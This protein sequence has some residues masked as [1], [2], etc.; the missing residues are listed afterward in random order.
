VHVSPL[1]RRPQNYLAVGGLFLC[2][3]LLFWLGTHHSAVPGWTPIQWRSH[4]RPYDATQALLAENERL[5]KAFNDTRA[6][7]EQA[8]SI[9]TELADE[10]NDTAA[11]THDPQDS[12]TTDPPSPAEPPSG[13]AYVFYAT[14]DPY[15]CSALVNIH[16]LRHL[17]HARHPI[18]VLA[19]PTVSFP[20]IA[21]FRNAGAVVHIQTPPPLKDSG[22]GIGG[23]LGGG[24]YYQDCLLKLLAFKLHRLD[25]TLTR[26]L[27][28]D[29]DQLI[30]R[31]L[32]AL[33]AGLPPVD[34]AAPRAYW[35]AK[36][37]LASTFLLINLSDRLWATVEAAM[38]SGGQGKG[39]FDM[40]LLNEVLGD[41]VMM[42]SGEFVTLNSHWED[43]NL[44]GWYHAR[45][46]FNMTAVEM[47]DEMA[48]S[49]SGLAAPGADGGTVSPVME[50]GTAAARYEAGNRRRANG[51]F[52]L[53]DPAPE[54][55]T[56]QP[57]APLSALPTSS[58]PQSASPDTPAPQRDPSPQETPQQ[59][60]PPPPPS[61]PL[62][63][64]AQPRFPAT[65]PLSI[66]LDRLQNAAAVLHFTALGKPWVMSPAMARAARPDAHPLLAAQFAIWRETAGRVCPG[67]WVGY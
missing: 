45:S 47:G 54:A 9:Q 37:F 5:Q 48:K 26:V 64:A 51:P 21:A 56:Q 29:A 10:K 15:A 12:G 3:A 57:L 2:T 43:W 20:Y 50:P 18:H 1:M 22:G 63:P 40:D 66:E 49:G 38:K 55:S 60:P 42:L 46:E 25:P 27:A 17:L 28:F 44:P 30:L 61:L 13:Y 7:L 52:L 58:P 23:G 24:G 36:D 62:P 67:G 6:E 33:F 16:R 59:D 34:L 41:E 39:E 11:S 53:T 65:H 8:K 19:S 32:D 35:L 31:N 4:R 14:A